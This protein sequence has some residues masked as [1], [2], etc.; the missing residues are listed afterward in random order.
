MKSQ[1]ARAWND[2]KGADPMKYALSISEGETFVRVR[3]YTSVSEDLALE[4]LRA[5]SATA[6]KNNVKSFLFDVR[7]VPCAMGSWA[8]YE[9]AY[10]KLA[11]LG[12]RWD[13]RMALL[14]SPGDQTYDFLR[15]VA[16]NAGY[17]W[18]S[19]SDEEEAI[20][21]LDNSRPYEEDRSDKTEAGK[22]DSV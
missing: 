2:S 16:R 7:G 10:S 4:F 22:R 14:A 9:I 5:A 15:T 3:V 1:T 17:P 11:P 13:S 8:A 21:W 6:D 18:K 12:Y 20:A 19:F